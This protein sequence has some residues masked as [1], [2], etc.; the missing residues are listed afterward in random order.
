MSEIRNVWLGEGNKKLSVL[1]MAVRE[2]LSE[3][4]TTIKS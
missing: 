2:V 1:K 3:E 4:L